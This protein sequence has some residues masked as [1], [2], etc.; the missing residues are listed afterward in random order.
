MLN[1]IE[2]SRAVAEAVVSST[3]IRHQVGPACVPRHR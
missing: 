3:P 2:G 1:Q